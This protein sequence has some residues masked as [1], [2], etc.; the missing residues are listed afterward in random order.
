MPENRVVLAGHSLAYYKSIINWPLVIV[1]TIELFWRITRG[2]IIL[3][4]IGSDY[5]L[6]LPWILRVVFFI[7]IGR[8]VV[9]SQAKQWLAGVVAGAMSGFIIGIVIGLSQLIWQPNL[10]TFLDLLAL[11]WQT[12]A[13][14]A[15]IS[16]SVV[17]FMINWQKEKNNLINN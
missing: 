15:F 12:L 5:Y 8:L 16:G 10:E 3:G 7:Y 1:L 2:H 11:P 14:G 6:S 17:A 4:W 9:R 13:V